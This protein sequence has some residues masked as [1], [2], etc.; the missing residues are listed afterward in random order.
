MNQNRRKDDAR[1]A[2]ALQWG[3]RPDHWTL[4]LTGP[5]AGVI[6]PLGSTWPEQPLEYERVDVCVRRKAGP[7][8]VHRCGGEGA[9][10]WHQFYPYTSTTDEP[11]RDGELL[12]RE[13]AAPKLDSIEQYRLQMAAIGTAAMGYWKLG[14]SIHPDYDTTPLR[15]VAALFVKYDQLHK[16]REQVR[17]MVAMLKNREWAE[18]LAATGDAAELQSVIT[19]LVGGLQ[20]LDQDAERAAVEAW[21][22]ENQTRGPSMDDVWCIYLH[23]KDA[24]RREKAA[25]TR[26]SMPGDWS[27][28]WDAYSPAGTIM[29]NSPKWGGCFL[30]PPEPHDIGLHALAYRMLSDFLGAPGQVSAAAKP[31]AVDAALTDAVMHGTGAFRVHG[32][33]STEH[34]DMHQDPDAKAAANRAAA[35]IVAFSPPA[36][37]RDA[38]YHDYA[39]PAKPA[40]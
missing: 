2:V 30:R 7:V 28:T 20:P 19:E 9:A 33:G 40:E 38:L 31:D 25:A 8:A 22:S 32:D 36:M 11:L 6:G 37:V 17:G 13:G 12:Y 10:N 21:A 26:P 23:G 14:D 5:N 24:G 39:V 16:F 4:L 35:E 1:P 29:L 27:V 34:V 18:D 3:D 15:D